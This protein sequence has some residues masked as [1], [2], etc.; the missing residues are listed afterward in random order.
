L[1]SEEKTKVDAFK[2][3]VSIPMVRSSIPAKVTVT[4]PFLIGDAEMSPRY[5]VDTMVTLVDERR[6]RL[7]EEE[8]DI[9][10]CEIDLMENSGYARSQVK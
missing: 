1:R 4:I 7:K 6:R 9:I 5:T 2:A 8:E 3:D 10:L